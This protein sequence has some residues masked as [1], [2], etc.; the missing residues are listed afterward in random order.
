MTETSAIA[1]GEDS[2]GVLLPVYVKPRSRAAIGG[3]RA[4]ALVVS[5][6]A[7]PHEG[8]A[9]IAVTEAVAA[10]FGLP[11]SSVTVVRGTKSRE[12]LIRL[13]GMSVSE[14]QARL[15]AVL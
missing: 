15:D 2:Q 4:G 3:V 14:A 13:S 7:P 9:N 11:K 10:A 5:V 12:K 8:A 6:A 1:L